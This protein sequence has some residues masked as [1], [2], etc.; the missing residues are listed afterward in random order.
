[1]K[2]KFLIT[3]T[4]VNGSRN[5]LLSQV[6]KKIALYVVLTVAVALAGVAI[7]MKYLDERV[8]RLSAARKELT[9]QNDALQADVITLQKNI[10]VSKQ[11]FEEIEGK[12]AELEEQYGLTENEG[13]LTNRIE[14]ITLTAAEE[15]VIAS[16]IPIGKVIDGAVV[17]D[18]YGWR[19]H[20]VL[21]RRIFH[22][23]LDLKANVG[24]PVY[25][26]A[27]G[28]VQFAGN[29]PSGYGYLVEISHNFGFVT[30]Y[31][32]L[33]SKLPVKVGDFVKRGDLIAYSGNT[34]MTTG[35]HLH[36]EI[37]F[38]QRP[39]DPINFIMC[40]GKNYKEL[41][42]KESRVSWQSLV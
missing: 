35:P 4:D 36:Y 26:P 24:T 5:I 1:M 18:S 34:G 38:I 32:H 8:E 28:V 17:N 16:Q 31:A 21:K 33:S 25:S 23:G 9:L 19:V 14:N 42:E 15:Y 22:P 20:P 30:R 10:E 40:D 39:L 27:D 6:V 13:N 12:I 3:I 2:N 41:F 29:G 37:R 11:Q 7:Y